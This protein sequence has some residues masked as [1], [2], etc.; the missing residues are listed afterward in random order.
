MRFFLDSPEEQQD[1]LKIFGFSCRIL[2]FSCSHEQRS[3]NHAS[4]LMNREEGRGGRGQGGAAGGGLRAERTSIWRGRG[5]AVGTRWLLVIVMAILANLYYQKGRGYRGFVRRALS[6][7]WR[8]DGSIE[9]REERQSLHY[10]DLKRG[11]GNREHASVR[12]RELGR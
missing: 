3:L 6:L 11:E 12:E 7:Q 5:S 8:L 1:S 2:V 10:C 4:K 9:R